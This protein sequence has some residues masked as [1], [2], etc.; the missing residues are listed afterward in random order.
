MYLGVSTAFVVVIAS[1]VCMD[2]IGL[3][4][5]QGQSKIGGTCGEWDI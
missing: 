2:G 3:Y 4:I 1:T 5:V